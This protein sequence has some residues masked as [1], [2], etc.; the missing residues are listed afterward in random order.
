[1]LA[2]YTSFKSLDRL[3]CFT[4]L[5]VFKGILEPIWTGC[6]GILL[7]VVSQK[8]M[9]GKF[10]ILSENFRKQNFFSSDIIKIFCPCIFDGMFI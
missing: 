9:K 10:T 6:L 1:M 8:R 7:S 4:G 2:V 5:S 3:A